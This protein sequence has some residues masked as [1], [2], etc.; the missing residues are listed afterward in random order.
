MTTGVQLGNLPLAR[1]FLEEAVRNLR[2]EMKDDMGS[3]PYKM[4]EVARAVLR[5][6]FNDLI[7]ELKQMI[8]DAKVPWWKYFLNRAEFHRRKE[9]E[10]KWPNFLS[11]EAAIDWHPVIDEKYCDYYFDKHPDNDFG[12]AFDAANNAY[13]QECVLLT[14]LMY[15]EIESVLIKRTRIVEAS[16][17]EN[18]FFIAGVEAI[19][20]GNTELGKRLYDQYRQEHFPELNDRKYYGWRITTQIW[21]ALGICGY[22][23]WPSYPYTDF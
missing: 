18:V 17:S 12:A 7:R 14:Q 13:D 5:L 11:K 8:G 4:E 10:K 2:E 6:G 20:H 1:R 21:M 16:R 3:Y 9:S 22:A 15:G 19:R 23:P